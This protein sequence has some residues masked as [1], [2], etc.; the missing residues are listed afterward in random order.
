[1]ATPPGDLKHKGIVV[2]KPALFL[3]P[4]DRVKEAMMRKVLP[5]LAVLVLLAAGGAGGFLLQ[6][7]WAIR[8]PQAPLPR[9]AVLAAD[10]W[11]N[12]EKPA[13]IAILNTA[14]QEMTRGFVLDPARDPYSSEPHLMSHPS[15]VL[16]WADGRILLVDVG[17]S[18][19]GAVDFGWL[20]EK[21]GGGEPIEAYGGV[22]ER[23][24]EGARHV[25]GVVFTHLHTDHVEGIGALCRQVGHPVRVFMTEAQ[26][27]R[28]N[29]TTRAGHKLLR[30]ASCVRI[31]RL[32][33]ASPFRLDGFPGVAVVAAGGH[34]PGSQFVL[35]RVADG[36]GGR[37][38]A[39]TGDIV[40]NVDGILQDIPKP[41][42]YRTFVVPED[43]TR[44]GDLRRFLKRLHDEHGFTLLVSHDQHALAQS[45]VPFR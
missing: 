29:Y 42:F 18:R 43:D 21:L 8:R 44:L 37:S 12:G 40:N 33:G 35:A 28:P 17:M 5:G 45:G 25:Q 20:I 9:T 23:L 41:F 7:H 3:R 26:A 31:E 6:A 4:H 22:A 30:E 19:E 34:T 1:V 13:R 27:E 36:N 2:V 38:Y 10:D 15:F 14:T 16:E 11:A 39:F 24:G 32:G